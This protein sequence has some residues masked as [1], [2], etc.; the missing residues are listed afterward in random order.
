M[1]K[2]CD[3]LVIS[4]TISMMMMAMMAMMMMVLMMMMVRMAKLKVVTH[5]VNACHLLGKCKH[6]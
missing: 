2:W 3:V 5:I 6:V 1:I 4:C